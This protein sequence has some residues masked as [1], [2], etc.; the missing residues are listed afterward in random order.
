MTSYLL[1]LWHIISPSPSWDMDLISAKFSCVISHFISSNEPDRI[2]KNCSY[3]IQILISMVGCVELAIEVLLSCRCGLDNDGTWC[4][5]CDGNF[6]SDSHHFVN[7]KKVS[8]V[9]WIE[10]IVC[11]VTAIQTFSF[12]SRPFAELFQKSQ[13]CETHF[14]TLSVVANL[15]S[16]KH[17]DAIRVTIC[18]NHF[19]HIHQLLESLCYS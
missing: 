13:R 15:L 6:I 1:K 5:T 3:S 19:N 14:N 4:A 7:L 9:Y 8:S 11:V 16:P 10:N 17:I 12:S 2:S 18:G